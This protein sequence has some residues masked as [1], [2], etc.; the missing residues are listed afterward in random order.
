MGESSLQNSQ[1]IN[2]GTSSSD[3][4]TLFCVR[5]MQELL[6]RFE[7]P[8]LMGIPPS[9]PAD[10]LLKSECTVPHTMYMYSQTTQAQLQWVKLHYSRWFLAFRWY[11]VKEH[12]CMYVL[13]IVLTNVIHIRCSVKEHPHDYMLDF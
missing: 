2:C 9:S 12:T 4:H 10:D 6:V 3:V 8:D 1:K 5:S 13:K 11:I 7:P